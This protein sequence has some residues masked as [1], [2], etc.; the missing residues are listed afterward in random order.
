MRNLLFIAVLAAL[1]ISMFGCGSPATKGMGSVV[2]EELEGAPEWVITGHG[3]DNEEIYG[4]GSAVGTNNVS[5]ARS[6]AQGRGRTE[7]AR[8]LQLKVAAMLKDYQ[9]TTTGGEE[10]G[11]AAA[12]EQHIVD[13]AKQIT[14]MTLSGT[15]QKESW[16]SKTGALYVL[17][18]LDVEH[19]KDA[20]KKMDNL[21]EEIRSA[22]IE[23]ADKAFEELDAETE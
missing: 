22:V 4:L 2:E 9:A 21:S 12:D 11:E 18:A 6:A 7:I 8:S 13:V 1:A 3:G 19:F 20:V 10:F 14:D 23:R 16:I 15:Y 5:L 17:M